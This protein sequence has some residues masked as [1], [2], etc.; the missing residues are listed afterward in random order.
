VTI[1]AAA[2][3]LQLEPPSSSSAISELG[4][5][6]AEFALWGSLVAVCIGL[7]LLRTLC[8][9]L[10]LQIVEVRDWQE[11]QTNGD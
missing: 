1:P 4:A 3:P 9:R 2:G 5:D 8:P 10:V 11:S 7:E 6:F